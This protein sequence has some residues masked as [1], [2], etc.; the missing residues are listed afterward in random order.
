MN[1]FLYEYAE[2]KIDIIDEQDG[3]E[4]RKV[5][6]GGAVDGEYEE[7]ENSE[8][9]QMKRLLMM[10]RRRKLTR[11]INL[12]RMMNLIRMLNPVVNVV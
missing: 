2:L 6:T 4:N 12:I 10:R 5:Q 3:L 7:Y 9:I 11:M 1:Q 8:G